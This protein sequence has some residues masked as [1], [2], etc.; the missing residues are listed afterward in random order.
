MSLWLIGTECNWNDLWVWCTFGKNIVLFLRSISVKCGVELRHSVRNVLNFLRLPC[1]M[2]DRAWRYKHE[3]YRDSNVESWKIISIMIPSELRSCSFAQNGCFIRFHSIAIEIF[4]F[5]GL[6]R[7][8][9]KKKV[10]SSSWKTTKR[11]LV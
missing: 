6:V 11:N 1:Y 5:P 10:A 2:H 9:S 8:R 7:P 3:K 4:H